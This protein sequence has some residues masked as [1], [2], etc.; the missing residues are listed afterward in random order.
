MQAA[1]HVMIAARCKPFRA[2]RPLSPHAGRGNIA[3]ELLARTAHISHP[4]RCTDPGAFSLCD[5]RRGRRDDVLDVE[6]FAT[7]AASAGMTFFVGRRCGTASKTGSVGCV[8][9]TVGAFD[10]ARCRIANITRRCARRN[11]PRQDHTRSHPAHNALRTVKMRNANAQ[12]LPPDNNACGLF[13]RSSASQ[14]MP[15]G[16]ADGR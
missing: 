9:R 11:A 14:T 12:Q 2:R 15:H 10:L 6:P 5:L 1:K 4:A 16:A 7:S 8:R 3:A 13:Y